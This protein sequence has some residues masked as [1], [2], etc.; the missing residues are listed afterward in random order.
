MT[1]IYCIEIW[2]I[3]PKTHLTPLLP[4]QKK[5]VRIM[6]YSTF[7]T[8]TAPIVKEL[9]ILTVDK[10]AVHRIAIVMYKFN[11]GL[12]PAVL[13]TLYKKIMK[14]IHIIQDRKTCF[15]LHLELKSFQILISARIWNALIIKINFN[16]PMFNFKDCLKLFFLS[17]I[18]WI[19][20][21][22]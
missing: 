20:G 3:S 5:I 1:L 11:N 6:T 19:I 9:Q 18:A 2:G 22:P 14:Y 17:N 8:H 15:M 21:F 13:D 10:L 16:I 7:Y 4:L 12:L